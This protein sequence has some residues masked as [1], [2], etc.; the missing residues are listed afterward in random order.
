[1]VIRRD[2]M[3]SENTAGNI[4]RDQDFQIPTAREQE[5]LR[6]KEETLQWISESAVARFRVAWN[7]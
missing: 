5:L 1:M 4:E 6:R 2:K 7:H 3:N